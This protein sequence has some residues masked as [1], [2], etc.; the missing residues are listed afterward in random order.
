MSKSTITTYKNKLLPH[1]ADAHN[2]KG[3]FSR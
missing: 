3:T 1:A 2:H